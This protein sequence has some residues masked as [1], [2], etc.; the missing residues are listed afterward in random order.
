MKIRAEGTL[1]RKYQ[2]EGRPRG[3]IENNRGNKRQNVRCRWFIENKQ[4]IK[5]ADEFLKR[6]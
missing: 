3:V 1:A 5:N 2:N 4:F 6:I